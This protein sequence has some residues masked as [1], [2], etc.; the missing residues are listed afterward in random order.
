MART[1]AG[2]RM[3]RT[4]SAWF[5]APMRAGHRSTTRRD[6]RGSR[7]RGGRG[8]EEPVPPRRCEPGIGPRQRLTDGHAVQHHEMRD[9]VGGVE[10]Q[11]HRDIAAPVVTG[12]GEAVVTQCLHE[13]K[14]VSGHRALGVG[15]VAGGRGWLGRGSVT[16]QIRAHDAMTYRSDERSDPVPRRV[17]PRVTV[18]QQDRAA[19]TSAPRAARRR[20]RRRALR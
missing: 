2:S 1:V 20:R 7:A 19:R 14:H 8:V 5:S 4:K 16:P 12:D 18:Q 3:A 6:R 11:A 15:A 10:G 9:R 13:P 17:G